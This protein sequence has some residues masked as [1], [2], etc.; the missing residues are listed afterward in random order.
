MWQLTYGHARRGSTDRKQHKTQSVGV[1]PTPTPPPY[2]PLWPSF[3]LYTVLPSNNTRALGVQE[4]NPFTRSEPQDPVVWASHQIHTERCALV[5]PKRF[6]FH[7]LQFYAFI[8]IEWDL[9]LLLVVLDRI[10]LCSPGYH[11]T[12]GTPTSTPKCWDCR[13]TSSY[14]LHVAWF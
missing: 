6:S 8:L 4:T 10:L 5:I 14:P 13:H 3:S 2:P 7:C 9:C 12:G 1:L 11:Q